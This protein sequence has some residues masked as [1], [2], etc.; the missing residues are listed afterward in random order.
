[1]VSILSSIVPKPLFSPCSLVLLGGT[2]CL[3]Q[4]GGAP[5]GGGP[6][7]GHPGGDTVGRGSWSIIPGIPE[8][9]LPVAPDLGTRLCPLPESSES[10]IT[11]RRSGIW[12]HEFM[13]TT[14]YLTTIIFRSSDSSSNVSVDLRP[15]TTRKAVGGSPRVR[16]DPLGSRRSEILNPIPR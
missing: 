9:I 14:F 1:M 11:E 3:W 12:M 6:G 8:Y 13:T 5:S 7:A 2:C 4:L 10:S 15:E 16:E